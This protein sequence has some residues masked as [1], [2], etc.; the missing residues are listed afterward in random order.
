[1]RKLPFIV[2]ALVFAVSAGAQT[3]LTA[4]DIIARYIKTV[5]G[6]DKIQAIRTLRRIGKNTRATLT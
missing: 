3:P 1:M 4:D 5:G 6:A 2:T